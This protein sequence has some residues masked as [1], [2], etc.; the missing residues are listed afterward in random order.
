MFPIDY[1]NES[2]HVYVNAGEWKRV[3]LKTQ[4][5]KLIKAMEAAGFHLMAPYWVNGRLNSGISIAQTGTVYLE[6]MTGEYDAEYGFWG[7]GD[8][9]T[10]RISNH[11][12]AAGKYSHDGRTDQ[13][14]RADFE[15]TKNTTIEDV[16]ADAE[17]SF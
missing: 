11:E 6:F 16:L 1:H 8:V 12:S 4:T 10:V 9:Y 14:T 13:Y 15:V 7:E 2:G 5:K 17:L 3:T